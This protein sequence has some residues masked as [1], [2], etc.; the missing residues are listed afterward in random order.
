M[1]KEQIKQTYSMGDVV[2]R[3]GLHVNRAGFINCPF[4]SGDRS[5]SLKIYPDSFY[6]F[7]CGAGGDIFAFVERM[8]GCDFKEACS[9]ILR[10]SGW[11]Y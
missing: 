9:C 6:C 8:E 7:G 11:R 4:H 3:Y 10:R 5:A 1:D 2:L